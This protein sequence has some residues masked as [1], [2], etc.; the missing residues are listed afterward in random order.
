M[1][2]LIR[3]DATASVIQ[4]VLDSLDSPHSKRAYERHLREF[5]CWYSE[6]GETAI[7]KAVVQR[8]SVQLREA[9]VSA[10]SINQKLSAIRRLAIEAADNGAL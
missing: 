8:Y 10:S 1:K 2:D 5:I 4:I 6:S 9:G 7:T 3:Q